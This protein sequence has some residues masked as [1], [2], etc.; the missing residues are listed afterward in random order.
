MLGTT[1]GAIRGGIN[2]FKRFEQTRL[3]SASSSS[4]GSLDALLTA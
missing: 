1:M 3:L 2:V 4:S